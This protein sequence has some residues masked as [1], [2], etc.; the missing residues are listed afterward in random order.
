MKLLLVEDEPKMA[1]L[2]KR[3]L[4][5]EGHVVDLCATG[6]AALAQLENVSYDVIVLDWSLPEMDGL[7][8]LR[9]LRERSDRTPVLM[10]TARGTIGERVLGLRTGA[11]DYL[12]KPFD[13]EELLA[14]LEGLHR[15]AAGHEA[16][17]ALG[18]LSF[19]RARRA[20][21]CGADEQPLTAREFQ[22]FDELLGHF[23][24]TLSRSE[25]LAKVWGGGLDVDPNV[26]DVYV[27]YLRSKLQK[28]GVR[29]LRIAAVRGVGYRLERGEP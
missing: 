1:Q 19:D 2:L 9:K 29:D 22:L 23:G 3:G 14:R 25:I 13:F 17:T 8:V 27:G 4:D 20:L 24:D 16:P 12:I 18:S 28:L 10:L 21:R 26:V 11:D 15:R 7:T 5:E 6:T